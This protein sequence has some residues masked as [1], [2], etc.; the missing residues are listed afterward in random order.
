M[1]HKCGLLELSAWTTTGMHVM[2]I[3]V[4]SGPNCDLL[5]LNI[6]HVTYAGFLN[7]DPIYI[8]LQT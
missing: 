6:L 7:A 8:N 1:S 3:V 4:S 2:T 5:E